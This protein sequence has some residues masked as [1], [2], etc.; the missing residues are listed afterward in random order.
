MYGTGITFKNEEGIKQ[1]VILNAKLKELSI[2]NPS[3]IHVKNVGKP[4]LSADIRRGKIL[5]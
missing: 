5:G 2:F 4:R 1:K 3:F